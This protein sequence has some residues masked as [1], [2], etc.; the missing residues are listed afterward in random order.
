MC[1]GF[2]TD[3]IYMNAMC[4]VSLESRLR[5]VADAFPPFK[6]SSALLNN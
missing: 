5:A 3:G 2:T 1:T 6:D 4:A